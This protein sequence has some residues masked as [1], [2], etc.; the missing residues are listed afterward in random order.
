MKFFQTYVAS[1]LAI[2]TALLVG[3]PLIFFVVGLIFASLG[4]S[5]DTVAVTPHTVLEVKLNRPIVEHTNP[6]KLDFDLGK[7]FPG[8]SQPIGLDQIVENLAK[9][10]D[11]DRID[12]IYL[13]LPSLLPASG[14]ATLQTL[15]ESLIDFKSGGK[16]VYAY[17]EI[18]SEQS[19]YLASVADSVYLAPGGVL[20]FNGLASTPVFFAGTLEKLDIQPNIFRVGT[21]KSA[22]EPFLRKNLSP[23]ARQ[24]QAAL[25]EDLWKV[26]A[27]EVALSRNLDAAT[28]NALAESLILADGRQ[29]QAAGLVD[30]AGYEDEVLAVLR[31]RSAQPEDGKAKLM[32]FTKYLKT[33][34][35]NRRSSVN[36]VAV[37][38]A[39]GAIQSGESTEGVIGSQTMVEALRK[40]REDDKI[41][42][43][44]L[45]INS[46]GGSAL[47]S[48]IITRELE[49]LKAEKPLIAS[50][51]DM[52]AS[53]GYY[54]AAPADRIF[55]SRNTITGSIGIFGLS[56]GVNEF[57]SE[58]LGMTFDEVKTHRS[59]NL[60]NPA[61]P[62]SQADSLFLQRRVERG[63]GDFIEVVRKGR[64]FADSAAVDRIAQGRVWSGEDAL[65]RQLVDEFGDLQAAVAYAAEQAGLGEDYRIITLPRI[66][67]PFEKLLDDKTQVSARHYWAKHPLR[68]EYQ[69]LQT[70]KHYYPGSGT[71]ALMPY[72]LEIK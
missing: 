63:Y 70:F 21:Y 66:K 24:Q 52:A 5:K 69:H 44:V 43:V 36:K 67:N 61:L 71:Y 42:A 15:R 3:I 20:E 26:F 19:Y 40:A 53:G 64:G 32:K 72:T 18:Y 12:G 37:I 34:N 48:E 9:A 25:L 10:K 41:K 51:G 33:P 23:E 57:F 22:V 7:L 4:S 50:M 8:A 68:E 56:F 49:L 39:E 59:A 27:G 6:S 60:G 45:R 30:V 38:F 54:L 47:A 46:P 16:F 2:I 17:G 1:F 62:M 35:P 55:A 29:A 14:W 13:Q 58:N 28:V 65:E 11:D 31:A